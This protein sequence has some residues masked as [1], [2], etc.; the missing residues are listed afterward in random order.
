MWAFMLNSLKQE[1]NRQNLENGL[2]ESMTN[3]AGDESIKDVFLDDL[4]VAVLGAENDPKVKELVDSIPEYDDEAE[5]QGK[6]D[7]LTESL[8]LTEI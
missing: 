8:A 4:D 3:A 6:I 7:S 1:I 2:M 5:I